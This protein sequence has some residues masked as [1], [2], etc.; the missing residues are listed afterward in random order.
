MGENVIK[1][2][3]KDS[4]RSPDVIDAPTVMHNGNKKLKVAYVMSRFPKLTETS[5]KLL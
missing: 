4:E 3:S 2:I 1:Q 5:H